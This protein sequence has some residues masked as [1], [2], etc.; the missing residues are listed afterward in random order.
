MVES[1]NGPSGKDLKVTVCLS[2]LS[3]VSSN[4]VKNIRIFNGCEVLIENSVTN[5]QTVTRVPE[6]LVCIEEPLRILFLTYSSFNN[7]I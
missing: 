6:F 5:C 4:F 7:S 3:S 2:Y 1:H